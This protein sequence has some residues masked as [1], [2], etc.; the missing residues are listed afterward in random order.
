MESRLK[1]EEQITGLRVVVSQANGTIRGVLKLPEGV[2]LPA[3]A[4]LRVSVRSIEDPTIY[5]APVDADANGQF[6]VK[7][8]VAGTYQ[9]NVSVFA[10][11]DD[12]RPRILRPAQTVMVTNGAIA[13]ATITLQIVK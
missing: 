11:P 8:L 12:Q 4:R 7:D 3:T 6:L 2:E 10:G 13:E 9:F 5:V 1:N